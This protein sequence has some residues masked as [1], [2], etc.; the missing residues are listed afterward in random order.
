MYLL[1]VSVT[2]VL[3]W[4]H[5]HLQQHHLPVFGGVRLADVSL[6]PRG[7]EEC[8]RTVF[9]REDLLLLAFSGAALLSLCVEHI[10]SESSYQ[11]SRQ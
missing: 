9:A 2:C 11:C 7:A 4:S 3:L 6:E 5:G 1:D 10:W 8:G